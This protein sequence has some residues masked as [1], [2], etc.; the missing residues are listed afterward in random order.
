MARHCRSTRSR[1]T[2]ACRGYKLRPGIVLRARVSLKR[3]FARPVCVDKQKANASSIHADCSTLK[4]T[5]YGH[6]SE[7]TVVDDRRPI[8]GRGLARPAVPYRPCRDCDQLR[9]LKADHAT[10]RRGCRRRSHKWLQAPP[11]STSSSSCRCRRIARA[12][13]A[14]AQ[15]AGDANA[16]TRGAPGGRLFR[17]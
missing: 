10:P 4:P 3:S 1:S 12:C 17:R 6:P 16:G 9:I 8:R 14:A 7:P 5:A 2:E 15:R 13:R 11:C